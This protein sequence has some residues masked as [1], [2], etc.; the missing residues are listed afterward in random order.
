MSL[1]FNYKILSV[2]S[3]VYKLLV[4]ITAVVRFHSFGGNECNFG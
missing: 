3:V 4:V 2:S 1:F